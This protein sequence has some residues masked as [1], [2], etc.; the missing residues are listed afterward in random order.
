ME[1]RNNNYVL[2]PKCA[3]RMQL[4]VSNITN[5]INILVKGEAVWRAV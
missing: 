1:W 3:K 2:K 4:R 5:A